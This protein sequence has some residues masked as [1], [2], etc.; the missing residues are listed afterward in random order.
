MAGQVT[1][2][3]D[4]ELRILTRKLRK[5]AGIELSRGQARVINTIARKSKTRVLREV[6]KELGIKNKDLRYTS[7]K[8]ETSKGKER[9][10][11][12]RASAR[13]IVAELR[14]SARGIPLI[15]LNP[16][17]TKSGVKAGRRKVVEGAFIATPTASPK[18]KRKGR[19]K[20]PASFIGKS[21]V[22]KRK[23]RA[24]YPLRQQYVSVSKRLKAGMQKHTED[25][26]RKEAA[27]MMKKELEYR[28][29]KQAGFK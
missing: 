21:Q 11:I 5:T 26:L 6:A 18:S 20:L 24:A 28:V 10:N 16:R 3:I 29:A 27:Q 1:G 25:I 22:F 17:Q 19:G 14:A 13:M 12:R 23:G 9:L 15:K 8:T 4:K 2:D 7:Q